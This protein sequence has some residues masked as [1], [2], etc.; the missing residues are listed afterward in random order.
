[1]FCLSLSNTTF[2]GEL[3]KTYKKTTKPLKNSVNSEK[4]ERRKHTKDIQELTLF[5]GGSEINGSV[6]A[7]AAE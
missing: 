3:G 1:M 4:L 6:C 5:C 2:C 7:S